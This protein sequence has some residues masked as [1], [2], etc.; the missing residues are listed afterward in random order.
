MHGVVSDKDSSAPLAYHHT[1]NPNGPTS[2]PI[3]RIFEIQ[4][5]VK[6]LCLP[7]STTYPRRRGYNDYI[8]CRLW[9]GADLGHL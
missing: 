1:D 7:N 3:S 8:R 9:A 6:T 4:V 5:R 2:I